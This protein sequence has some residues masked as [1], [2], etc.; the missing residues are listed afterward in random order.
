MGFLPPSRSHL[1]PI[2]VSG[3]V[4]HLHQ[5]PVS[6][7]S[8][9][10]ESSLTSMQVVP[11]RHPGPDN[12]ISAPCRSHPTSI[13]GSG[14]GSHLHVGPSTPHSRCKDLHLSSTQVPS[15]LHPCLENYNSPPSRSRLTSSSQDSDSRLPSIQHRL[16]CVSLTIEPPSMMV[17]RLNMMRWGFWSALNTLL[18]SGS[19]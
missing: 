19:L 18:K 8:G 5:G 2:H 4:S 3:C 14:C 7:A 1:I 10:Q 9:S 12:C 11:H 13:Q 15:Y 6:P 17:P 16:C